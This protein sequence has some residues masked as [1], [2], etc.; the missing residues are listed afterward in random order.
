VV[1]GEASYGLYLIHIPVLHLFLQL[2]WVRVPMLFPAYLAIAIGLSV[3]SFY[4]FETPTRRWLLQQRKIH[5][6]ETMEMASD[7]Q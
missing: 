4:Y 2:G 3:L 6:K 1:L 7:A 5:V